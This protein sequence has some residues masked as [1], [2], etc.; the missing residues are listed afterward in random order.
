MCEDLQKL[1]ESGNYD[2]AIKLISTMIASDPDNDSLLFQ[3]GK[4]FWKT[5]AVA[6]AMNDYAAAVKANPHSPAAVALEQAYA[7]QQFFN[8]DILNP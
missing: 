8:P 2:E 5:G 6:A 7:V 3:R 4:L 1:I